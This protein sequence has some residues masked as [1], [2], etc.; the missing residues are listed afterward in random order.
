MTREVDY[1]KAWEKVRREI[2]KIAKT[3]QDVI[4]ADAEYWCGVFG[5]TMTEILKQC[6]KRAKK[7][8]EGK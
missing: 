1:K 6:T 4:H 7:K 3:Q 5:D 8:T 2:K